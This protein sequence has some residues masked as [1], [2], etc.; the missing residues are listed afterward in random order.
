VQVLP[1]LLQLIAQR[2]LRTV[3][4]REALPRVSGE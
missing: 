2:Q 1:R 4:L 3:T